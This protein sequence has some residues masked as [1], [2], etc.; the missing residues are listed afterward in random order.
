MGIAEILCRESFPAWTPA[1][2]LWSLELWEIYWLCQIISDRYEKTQKPEDKSK[3][4]LDSWKRDPNKMTHEA[5]ET[6]KKIER[7]EII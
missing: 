3:K 4:V 7:G 5:L 1:K 2:L 6:I